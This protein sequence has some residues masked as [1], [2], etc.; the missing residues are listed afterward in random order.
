MPHIDLKR[1]IDQAV[2]TDDLEAMHLKRFCTAAEG[3]MWLTKGWNVDR[4]RALLADRSYNLNLD[5]V[6][7]CHVAMAAVSAH[8]ALRYGEA[9]QYRLLH[10]EPTA[11]ADFLSAHVAFRA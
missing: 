3:E 10:P 9:E 1:V 6:N 8:G 7:L 5:E 4:A 11:L 2:M